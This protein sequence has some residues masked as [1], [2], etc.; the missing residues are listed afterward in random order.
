PERKDLTLDLPLDT[1]GDGIGEKL[2][3]PTTDPDVIKPFIRA[4]RIH[5]EIEGKP[6]TLTVL[7][8][9]NRGH[10]FLPF[11]DGTTGIETYAGGRFLDPKAK[12]NGNLV[13]D[14]N[15]AY[16]PWCAYG[17]GWSCPI[18]PVEN[19]IEAPIRAGERTFNRKG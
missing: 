8:D 14:L 18:P 13:V 2:D 4:G 3:I 15:Y 6:V 19:V 1:S 12:P 17:E 5:F 9:A 11:K 16:N 7:K 10:Y